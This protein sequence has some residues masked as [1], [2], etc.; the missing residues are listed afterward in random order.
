MATEIGNHWLSEVRDTVSELLSCLRHGIWGPTRLRHIPEPDGALRSGGDEPAQIVLVGDVTLVGVLE[1]LVVPA[2]AGEDCQLCARRLM[3]AG[4]RDRWGTT[5]SPTSSSN[6]RQ[7]SIVYEIG[8]Q[9]VSWRRQR[10]T[11]RAG[12]AIL[13]SSC[14]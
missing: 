10:L 8:S 5:S 11:S 2:G 14:Q 13:R 9:T 7:C 12:A 3:V 1:S 4:P 6:V